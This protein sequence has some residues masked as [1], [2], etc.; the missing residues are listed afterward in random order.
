VQWATKCHKCL[1]AR[2]GYK[3]QDPNEFLEDPTV[4]LLFY[5][6]ISVDNEIFYR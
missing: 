6:C 1:K 4:C 3:I 5:T 2:E